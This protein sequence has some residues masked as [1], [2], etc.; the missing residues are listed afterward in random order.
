MDSQTIQVVYVFVMIATGIIGFYC[1]AR[2]SYEYPKWVRIIV[3]SP[4][5]ISFFVLG[6]MIQGAHVAYVAD[7]AFGTSMC[8]L[9]ALVASRFSE[10]PLIDFREYKPDGKEFTDETK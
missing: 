5:L 1:S 2:L 3:L 9:Y 7:V 4:A 8:F 6:A 10:N